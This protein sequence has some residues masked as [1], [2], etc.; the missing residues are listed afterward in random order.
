[1]INVKLLTVGVVLNE[2]L[3]VGGGVGVVVVAPVL[4]VLVLVVVALQGRSPPQAVL[5][6]LPSRP[7]CGSLLLT[8]GDLLQCGCGDCFLDTST[9]Q[10]HF[11]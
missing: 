9:P 1:M 5:L 10:H 7:T 8:G 11:L 3:R 4:R 2:A 6:T